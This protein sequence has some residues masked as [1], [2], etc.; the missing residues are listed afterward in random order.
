MKK[1]YTRILAL[2]ATMM[3]TLQS[4]AQDLTKAFAAF[5]TITT[6]LKNNYSKIQALIFAIAAILFVVGL[7][8]VIPKFQSGDPNATKHAIAWAGGVIVLIVGGMFVKA[9]FG[10]T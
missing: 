7:I 9:A 2:S 5:D 8:Q 1:I 6:Q 10:I 4:H 3:L